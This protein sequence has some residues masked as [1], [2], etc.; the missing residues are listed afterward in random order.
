MNG[1]SIGLMKMKLYQFLNLEMFI[2][3][4]HSLYY[5]VIGTNYN[6]YIYDITCTIRMYS[7]WSIWKNESQ[8]TSKESTAKILHIYVYQLSWNEMIPAQLAIIRWANV[9][10][11]LAVL[12][13]RR[14]QMTLA[15]C[16]V[17]HRANLHL[18]WAMQRS[19][20]MI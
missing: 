16:D 8:W 4:F 13:A 20:D 10:I 6:H 14:W 3:F 15:R 19:S 9:G 5:S 1:N 11:L 17:A 2:P 18:R 7:H 12:L